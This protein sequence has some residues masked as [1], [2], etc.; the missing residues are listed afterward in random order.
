MPV[1]IY[2]HVT[3]MKSTYFAFPLSAYFAGNNIEIHFFYGHLVAVSRTVLWSGDIQVSPEIVA[4]D[5][6][7]RF[8]RNCPILATGL[9]HAECSETSE[10]LGEYQVG[11]AISIDLADMYS[12]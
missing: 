9:C 5:A 3:C 2:V 6:L 11:Q 10:M 1:S 12:G 4:S 7:A 8:D